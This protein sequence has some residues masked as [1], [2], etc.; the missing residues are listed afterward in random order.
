MKIIIP[1]AGIGSR[2]RPHTHTIPKILIKVAGKTIIEHILDELL[3]LDHKFSEIIFIVGHFG[4]QVEKY[5]TPKYKRKIRLKFVSQGERRGVGHAI[6]LTRKF[7]NDEP[8]FIILGDTIFRANFNRIIKSGKN[9]IGVKEVDDPRRFGIV[10]TDSSH[11]ITKF[12]EKPENPLSNLAIVGIY[13]IQN[14]GSLF[15][16]LDYIIKNNIKTKGEFQITDALQLMLKEKEVFRTFKIDKWLDCGKP[17]TLLSTNKEL[18]QEKH[19]KKRFKTAIIHS[20][21]YISKTASIK[22]SVIG[23]YVSIGDKAVIENSVIKNSIINDHAQINRLL[24]EGSVIGSNVFV[25]GVYRH[26]NIGDS[27]EVALG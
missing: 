19:T 8:V 15:T 24:L 21:V 3:K 6:Y 11:K 12:I 20:P 23:P 16:K 13:L 22:N 14:S 25:N 1:V 4:D 2:L 27:S 7:I 9:Y 10:F 26:L 18:L 17:E 5:I